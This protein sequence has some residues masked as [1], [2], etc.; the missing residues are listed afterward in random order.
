M[1]SI[2][3]VDTIQDQA[4]NNIINESSDTITIGASGDT[5]T[6]PSGASMTVPNGGLS[7]QNY[8]AFHA[9]RTSAQTIANSTNTTIIFDTESFDTDSAYDTATGIFTVPTGKDGKYVIYAAYRWQSTATFSYNLKLFINTVEFTNASG[10]NNSS[11]NSNLLFVVA[12]LS[13]GD[14]L[15]VTAFQDS[16]GSVDLTGSG[17]TT[18]FGAYRIGA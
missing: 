16:G 3:K 17:I 5:I 1:T 11:Y 13:A 4:G 14:D 9:N 8:P 6:I 2:L 7:G 15:N 12:D 18:Y 10:G